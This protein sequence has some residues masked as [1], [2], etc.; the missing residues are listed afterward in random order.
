M[1][2]C[3]TC[4]ESAQWASSVFAQTRQP[5]V[6]ISSPEQGGGDKQKKRGDAH[7]QVSFEWASD[8]PPIE[9]SRLAKGGPPHFIVENFVHAGRMWSNG[10]PSFKLAIPQTRFD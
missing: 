4:P 3:L 2:G 6:T 8:C 10:R 1:F 9:F 5:R 7:A